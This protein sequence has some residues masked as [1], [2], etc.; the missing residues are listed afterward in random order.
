M[1]DPLR[2]SKPVRVF[3]A[4]NTAEEGLVAIVVLLAPALERVMM[5]PRA[6]DPHPEE[7]LGGVF[8]LLLGFVYRPLPA[9]SRVASNVTGCGNDVPDYLVIGSVRV[10]HLP[11]PVM[12]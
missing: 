9:D 12:E 3:L 5:T 11:Q 10:N 6:L 7:Q 8:D 4:A 1:K 2:I